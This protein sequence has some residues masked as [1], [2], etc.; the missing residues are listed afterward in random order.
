MCGICGIVNVN[1][2]TVPDR[3]GLLERMRDTIAYR[4]PDEAGL[5]LG[6]GWALAI[7]GSVSSTWPTASSRCTAMTSAW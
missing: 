5:R 1:P 7:D 2:S 6:P 4:G 3:R